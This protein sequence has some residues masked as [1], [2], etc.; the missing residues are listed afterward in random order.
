MFS[1]KGFADQLHAEIRRKVIHNRIGF[2]ILGYMLG[3][4]VGHFLW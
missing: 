3:H 2:F 1:A 4:V